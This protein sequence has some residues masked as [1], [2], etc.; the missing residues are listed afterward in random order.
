MT[1]FGVGGILFSKKKKK[2]RVGKKSLKKKRIHQID[3]P[4]LYAGC[5]MSLKHQ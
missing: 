3:S 2:N 5:C 1:R 4:F